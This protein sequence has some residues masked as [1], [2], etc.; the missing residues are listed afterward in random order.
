MEEPALPACAFVGFRLLARRPLMLLTWWL[1]V[2]A[3]GSLVVGGALLL[4]RPERPAS[5]VVQMIAPVGG[6]MFLLAATVLLC[7]VFRELLQPEHRLVGL[8]LGRD[9]LRMAPVAL[10]LGLIL[11]V[12]MS[13]LLLSGRAEL[14][15]TAALLLASPFGCLIAPAIFA[16]HWRGLTAGWRLGRGRYFDLLGMNLVTW[17]IYATL[18]VLLGKLWV[19][20]IV[21]NDRRINDAMHMGSAA[22]GGVLS[23]ALVL[24][25]LVYGAL[26][27]IVAAPSAEAYRRL[28]SPPAPGP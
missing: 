8:R 2:L 17:G 14:A 4:L 28:T 5:F 11:T 21:A 24:A 10:A 27:V 7:A 25:V 9:E 13:P 3:M 20:L 15:V 26:L 23:V 18:S 22:F 19:W 16:L 6:P 1:G 12:G